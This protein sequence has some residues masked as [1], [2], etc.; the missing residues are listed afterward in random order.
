[1]GATCG[2]D[3]SLRS[4]AGNTESA[5]L[6]QLVKD[7]AEQVE[8]MKTELLVQ[9]DYVKN[10][11]TR[12]NVENI[13]DLDA[14]IARVAE[15]VYKSHVVPQPEPPQDDPSTEGPPGVLQLVSVLVIGAFMPKFIW[16]MIKEG[17]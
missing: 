11:S 8:D 1:M 3:I 14:E 17:L 4:D 15:E 9:K 5:Q 6:L 10:I 2:G 16:L 7:L 12:L 13:T